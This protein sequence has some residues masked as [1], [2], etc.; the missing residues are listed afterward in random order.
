MLSLIL[1][2]PVIWRARG[3]DAR[4]L[5]NLE[6]LA[7]N[8]WHDSCRRRPLP[9]NPGIAVGSVRHPAPM[10]KFVVRHHP[11]EWRMQVEPSRLGLAFAMHFPADR[12]AGDLNARR[13]GA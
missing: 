13:P 12:A 2:P 8:E 9:K 1:I 7:F 10:S 6:Q 5:F 4:R 11:S 3:T